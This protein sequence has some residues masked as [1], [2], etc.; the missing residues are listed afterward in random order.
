METKEMTYTELLTKQ[1]ELRKTLR[2][3]K[4]ET[5]RLRREQ[6]MR[7]ANEQHA[8]ETE[9]HNRMHELNN[10]FRKERQYIND[11]EMERKNILMDE[12]LAVESEMA[13]RKNE[14]A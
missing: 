6:D 13:E 8:L 1:A 9:Y 10:Q 4:H 11:G 14:E 12:L 3:L 2:E 7:L 5:S